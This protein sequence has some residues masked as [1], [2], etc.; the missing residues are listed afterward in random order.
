MHSRSRTLRCGTNL[1]VP[2]ESLEENE[3]PVKAIASEVA[4][5]EAV[6][7]RV[8]VDVVQHRHWHRPSVF[9]DLRQQRLQPANTPTL[10]HHWELKFEAK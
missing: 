2:E 4:T 8:L 3:T 6:L 5:V 9:L 7:Q 1:I 10:R